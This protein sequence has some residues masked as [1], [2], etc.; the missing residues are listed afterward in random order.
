VVEFEKTA[1]GAAAAGSDKGAL[2]T[3][4][5]PDFS[6]HLGRYVTR[7]RRWRRPVWIGTCLARTRAISLRE[8]LSFKIGKYQSVKCFPRATAKT[9]TYDSVWPERQMVRATGSRKTPIVSS[10]EPR[11]FP[12]LYSWRG[13]ATCE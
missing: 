7:T 8:L 6:F 11:R 2:P 13:G 3:I 12:A 9:L 4:A 5:F 1:L 10:Y